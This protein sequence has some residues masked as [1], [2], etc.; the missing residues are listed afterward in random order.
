MNSAE[1]LFL[2]RGV[3]ATTVD[4]ITS[5]AAVAKGTFYLYFS[6]KEEILA[7]LRNRFAQDLLSTIEAGIAEKAENDWKGKLA[8]WA[9]SSVAGYLGSIRLHDIVFF[10]FRP[11]SREGLTNNIIID[12]LSGLL[13]AGVDAKAWSVDEPRFTAVFLF[14]G[15]HGI[16]DAA[17]SR[18]KQV[19]RSRLAHKLQQLCFRA[20]GLPDG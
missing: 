8:A 9:R 7:A 11:P 14:S 6:S 3:G 17:Y 13:Q 12:H 16:V 10:E 15:F 20:V 5:D 4:Q 2:Q 19:N 1:R 18:D